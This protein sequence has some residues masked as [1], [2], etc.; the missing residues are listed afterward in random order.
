MTGNKEKVE[1]ILKTLYSAFFHHGYPVSREEATKIG[2]NILKPE[3]TIESLMWDIWID[4][5]NEMK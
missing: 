3:P 1:S 4:Y 5:R 2:L